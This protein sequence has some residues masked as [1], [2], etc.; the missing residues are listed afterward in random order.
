MIQELYDWALQTRPPSLDAPWPEELNVSRWLWQN[1]VPEFW[2]EEYPEVPDY[3]DYVAFPGVVGF[4]GRSYTSTLPVDPDAPWKTPGWTMGT[5]GRFDVRIENEAT[6]GHRLWRS[7]MNPMKHGRLLLERSAARLDPDQCQVEELPR[8]FDW[9]A[10]DERL[11][12][13]VPPAIMRRYVR[14]ARRI[15]KVRGTEAMLPLLAEILGIEIQMS[16]SDKPNY[17][18]IR[19]WGKTD[20]FVK[21]FIRRHLPPHLGIELEGVVSHASYTN[22]AM[23]AK[24]SYVPGT[25]PD[26]KT[27]TLT[28]SEYVISALI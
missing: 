27:S 21:L 22:W 5:G 16:W 28:S 15:E 17:R 14:L 7:L 1:S 24:A 6:F 20:Q 23:T 11:S 26:E 18:K 4:T 3:A 2:Q 8:L 12:H 19:V 13:D 9:V 25:T 10:G